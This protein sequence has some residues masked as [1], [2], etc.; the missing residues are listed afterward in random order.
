M[1]INSDLE[2]KSYSYL[3]FE[4]LSVQILQISGS[5]SSLL[6]ILQLLGILGKKT[7]A[8]SFK[9]DDL[10]DQLNSIFT[11][12]DNTA[13]V[14]VDLSSIKRPNQEST[15][16]IV[17]AVLGEAGFSL[18]SNLFNLSSH[19]TGAD[20][21]AVVK[22]YLTPMTITTTANK[23]FEALSVAALEKIPTYR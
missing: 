13:N 23:F 10:V 12:G 14:K 9:D 22:E 4:L 6:E 11:Q 21:L 3:S 7:M 5:G 18:S 19:L 1:N 17:Y 2:K 15:R 20:E 8:P 16:D